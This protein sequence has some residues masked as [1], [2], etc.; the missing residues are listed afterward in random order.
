MSIHYIKLRNN[1]SGSE[2]PMLG[3]PTKRLDNGNHVI[4]QHYLSFNQ[5]LDALRNILLHIECHPAIL[6]FA[7]QQGD[8][9]YLQAGIIGQENYGNSVEQ[10]P[11]KIVY[12]RKWLIAADTPT[13][14]VIQTAFLAIKKIREHE[15]R[16]LL[17]IK[18]VNTG[19]NSAAFSSHQDLPLMAGNREL[20]SSPAANQTTIDQALALIR[21]EKRQ[22]CVV[23][24]LQ[25]ANNVI[26]DVVLE[27]ARTRENSHE[28][29]EEFDEFEVTLVLKNTDGTLFIYA[30]MEALIEHSNRFVSENF[31]YKGFARFSVDNSPFQIAA[32]SVAT[33]Q[34]TKDLRDAQF[35]QVFSTNNYDVDASRK[36]SLGE[37][38]LADKNRAILNRFE[39]LDGHM[40]TGYLHD[41][42]ITMKVNSAS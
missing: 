42:Q 18:D 12:G 19:V 8:A 39:Q 1:V 25:R 14:E 23:N 15:V 16:E 24:V 35:A 22:F 36:P 6:L 21:F 5:D 27:Q 31:S 33:R 20:I 13:S 3:A 29:L 40:P 38:A 2:S 34:Y 28:T 4:P 26:V 17:T 11:K 30:L 9:L 41:E 7:G 10:P 37:G 32:L